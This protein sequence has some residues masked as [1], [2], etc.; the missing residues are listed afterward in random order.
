MQVAANRG[1][2]LP[3]TT[4][5][6]AAFLLA[7]IPLLCCGARTAV[8]HAVHVRSNP[9]HGEVL[10]ATPLFIEIWFDQPLFA[11]GGSN[12]LELWRGS[13]RLNVLEGTVDDI[14]RTRLA[15]G[16]PVTLPAGEYEVRWSTLSAADGDVAS[17]RFAFAIDPAGEPREFPPPEASP[18]LS[19]TPTAR[20]T[21]AAPPVPSTDSAEHGQTFWETRVATVLVAA[22][23][24]ATLFWALRRRE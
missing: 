19:F 12:V 9:R 2:S 6:T 23:G 5:L 8:A 16:I 18:H 1:G 15:A 14:D 11:R 4:A 20:G 17:G 13:E 3:R 10:G 24:I 22:V 21:E 7:L